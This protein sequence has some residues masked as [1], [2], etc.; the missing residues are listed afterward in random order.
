VQI[1][2]FSVKFVEVM[3]KKRYNLDLLKRTKEDFIAKYNE[4]K[5][6]KDRFEELLKKSKLT[7][8]EIEELRTFGEP[9]VDENLLV[10]A[11]RLEGIIKRVER[12]AIQ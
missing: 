6:D 10:E 4:Q 7:E 12:Y 9:I 5:E 1:G 3:E 2:G 8:K 11:N